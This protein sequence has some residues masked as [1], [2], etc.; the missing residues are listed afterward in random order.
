MIDI[1]GSSMKIYPLAIPPELKGISPVLIKVIWFCF[2]IFLFFNDQQDYTL[3]QRVNE[4]KILQRKSVQ[5]NNFQNAKVY[6]IMYYT[7]HSIFSKLKKKKVTFHDLSPKH[8]IKSWIS[9]FLVR[10][11]K[12]ESDYLHYLRRYRISL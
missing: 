8:V 10:V 7:I 4:I 2:I 6:H 1:L 9:V 5:K 11:K 12:K 3:S